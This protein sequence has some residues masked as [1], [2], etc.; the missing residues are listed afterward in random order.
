MKAKLELPYTDKD[1]CLLSF[2]TDNLVK[3]LN[4]CKKN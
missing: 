1:S 2:E 3:E 4:F